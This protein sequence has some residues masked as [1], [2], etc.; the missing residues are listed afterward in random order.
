MQIFMLWSQFEAATLFLAL[1][2]PIIWSISYVD[3]DCLANGDN[4]SDDDSDDDDDDD[5]DTV[6]TD[7]SS[8]LLIN[9]GQSMPKWT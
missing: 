2:K 4:V 7:V 5:C 1:T 9:D 6:E 8:M 3:V